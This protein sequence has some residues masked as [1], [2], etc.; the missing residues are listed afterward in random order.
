MIC[1]SVLPL[2]ELGQK[3]ESVVLTELI[4][5]IFGPSVGNRVVPQVVEEVFVADNDKL[6]GRRSS[7]FL[8]KTFPLRSSINFEMNFT[9]KNNCAFIF[10]IL[11]R[12]WVYACCG[13]LHLHFLF[14]NL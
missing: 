12:N 13:L 6:S 11:L 8:T 9:I 10:I 4:E 2:P 3:I 14:T 7:N 1:V 5:T